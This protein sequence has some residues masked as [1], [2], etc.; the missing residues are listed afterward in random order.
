[1]VAVVVGDSSTT[2]TAAALMLNAAVVAGRGGLGWDEVGWGF[3]A[4]Q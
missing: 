4:G 3:A 2:S 1:M